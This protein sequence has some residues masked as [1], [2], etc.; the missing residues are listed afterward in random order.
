MWQYLTVQSSLGFLAQATP[1]TEWG[2]RHFL[3]QNPWL[4]VV[5]MALLIPIVAI[6]FGTVTDYLRKTRVAELDAALKR[7]MLERGMT[8][9]QIKTVLEAGSTKSAKHKHGIRMS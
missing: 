8:P 2:T 7:D 1:E 6:V 3:F 5:C 4:I 9:D